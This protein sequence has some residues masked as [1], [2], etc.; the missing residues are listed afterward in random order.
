MDKK[1]IVVPD[2]H[3]RK[4][5]REVVRGNEEEKIIFLGD[6]L[7]PYSREGISSKQ[8][9]EELLAIIE[10]KKHHPENVNLLLGNHD[11]GYLDPNISTFRQDVRRREVY[12]S[13]FQD[14]LNLFN[15]VYEADVGDH[16]IL[17]SHAG[18]RTTWLENNDWLLT[19]GKFNPNILNK[20]LHDERL[21]E[22]LFYALTDS[23]IFRGGYDIA[24]SVV[25]A[26]VE[27]YVYYKDELPGYLQIFGHSLH[28]GGAW[29]IR[30]RLWCIDCAKGFCFW[31]N[32]N[33]ECLEFRLI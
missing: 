4:F 20:I 1:W 30:N 18:V 12:K 26:D 33:R 16:T 31:W 6:Y 29:V 8:A 15:L 25:W 28:Q 7:D 24:G 14:N 2:V 21:R 9:Y 13:I 32:S 11:L 22:D 5:W 23:S 27:E 10:F 3:G 19:G 17:F